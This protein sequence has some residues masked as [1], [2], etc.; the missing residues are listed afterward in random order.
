MYI[1]SNT[2]EFV[3]WIE[4][5]MRKRGMNQSDVARAGNVTRSAINKVLTRSQKPGP[6][7]CAAFA[8]AFDLPPEEV[9]RRAGLIPSAPAGHAVFEE[10]ARYLFNNL[11]EPD[12][13]EVIEYMQYRLQKARQ[14]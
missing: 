7:V 14:K 6:A 1:V 10:R 2:T 9:L 12:Q 8:K 4:S 11:P 13:Q 3:L 5:E